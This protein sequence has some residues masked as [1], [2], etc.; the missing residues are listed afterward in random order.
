M[1]R[2][3]VIFGAG[4]YAQVAYS[5]FR[6]ARTHDVVAF[7]VDGQYVDAE[8]C[9]GHPLVAFEDLAERYP[10]ETHDLFVAVGYA[11]INGVR[12][13]KYEKGKALG[14][15]MASY[16]S[17]HAVIH[18]DAVIGEHCFI[19]DNVV[20]EPLARVGDNVTIWTGTMIA[21]FSEVAS[22]CFISAAV[23]VAGACRIG[24]QCF[25]GVGAV[26]RDHLEIGPRTVVGAGALLLS[27]AAADGVYIGV[28]TPR[29][30]FPSHHLK[31]L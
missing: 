23:Q 12:R 21:H 13:E 25:L 30:E 17:P 27:D 5:Y 31:R 9:H 14:Y 29:A 7:T 28:E 26:L 10:P 16:V 18:P 2:P 20:V 4:E 19:L 22:H 6:Q 24:E 15:A 3:L 8:T 1:T 11:R